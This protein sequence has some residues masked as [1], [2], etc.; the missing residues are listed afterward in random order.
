MLLETARP[1]VAL[2]TPLEPAGPVALAVGAPTMLREPAKLV[3]APIML[4]EPAGLV[5][6]ST[7]LLEPSG[8]LPS[9]VAA[10]LA[11]SRGQR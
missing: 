6:A 9:A 10:Q 5:V 1:V 8:P 11:H 4:L 3:V 7:M 2:T